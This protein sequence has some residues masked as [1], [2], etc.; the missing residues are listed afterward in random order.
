MEPSHH[1]TDSATLHVATGGV[2]HRANSVFAVT[3]AAVPRDVTPLIA[4]AFNTRP[5]LDGP[6]S[7]S[8]CSYVTTY[9]R[10]RP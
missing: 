3:R 5:S 4:T 10:S 2:T 9:M 1:R 7:A 6:P 8:Y